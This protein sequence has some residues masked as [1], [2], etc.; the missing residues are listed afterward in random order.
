MIGFSIELVKG[1]PE[2]FTDFSHDI[3]A[4]GEHIVS[5]YITPVFSNEHQMNM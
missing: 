4:S 2:T 3:F 1:C 5:K